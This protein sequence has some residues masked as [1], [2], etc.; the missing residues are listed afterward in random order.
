MLGKRIDMPLGEKRVNEADFIVRLL[1]SGALK[2]GENGLTAGE[3][4]TYE[5]KGKTVEE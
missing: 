5:V 2:V 4:G 3:P 1:V